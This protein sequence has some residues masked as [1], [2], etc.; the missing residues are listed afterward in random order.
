MVTLESLDKKFEAF[1]ENLKKL[2]QKI[3]RKFEQLDKKIDERIDDLAAMTA[4]GFQDVE[5]R[6]DIIEENYV[7]K[8]D[9]VNFT[10]LHFK[11]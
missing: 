6:L 2:D 8:A 11:S 5:E 10:Q 7:T 4:R 9:L 1:S 3:D